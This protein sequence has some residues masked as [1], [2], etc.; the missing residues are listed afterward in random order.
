MFNAVTEPVTWAGAR[1]L[2]RLAPAVGLRVLLSGVSTA[3]ARELLAGLSDQ[4]R[5]ALVRL[6]AGMRSGRGFLNDL[7]GAADVTAQVT[8]PVL[9]VAS[10]QDGGVPFGHAEALAASLPQAE[11][12]E[13]GASSHFIWFGDDYPAIAETIRQLPATRP[14]PTGSGS[15]AEQHCG[16]VRPHRH[17]SADRPPGAAQLTDNRCPPFFI[18]EARAADHDG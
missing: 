1:T 10:H 17:C 7:R 6:F 3:P 16:A 5:A 12:V 2:L 11:L 15:R 4:D 18:D 8:Q 14:H 13:S 9:I